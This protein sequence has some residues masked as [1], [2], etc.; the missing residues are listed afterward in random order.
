MM[1]DAQRAAK[2]ANLER[3]QLE[4]GLRAHRDEIRRCG[5]GAPNFSWLELDYPA[6]VRA[7]APALAQVME[8]IGRE[9]LPNESA[10]AAI[11]DP[12]LHRRRI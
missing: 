11:I 9:R 4:R 3:E 5:A 1:T 2:E 8:F 6:L 7:R 10:L 12:A